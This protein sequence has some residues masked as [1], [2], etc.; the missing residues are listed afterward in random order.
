MIEADVDLQASKLSGV[1]RSRHQLATMLHE[2][3][4][5]REALEEKIAE[6]R[7]NRKEAGNKYGALSLACFCIATDHHC[8]VSELSPVPDL[9]RNFTIVHHERIYSWMQ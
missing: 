4:N 7:R 1:A 3:Y 2:A 5:N 6:G 8:Q 9:R